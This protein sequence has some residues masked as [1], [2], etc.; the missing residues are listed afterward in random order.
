MEK[1]LNIFDQYFAVDSATKQNKSNK[2]YWYL[3]AKPIG[4][5]DFNKEQVEF[6]SQWAQQV[7]AISYVDERA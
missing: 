3:T 1:K 4:S 2:T 6:A 5:S 7:V